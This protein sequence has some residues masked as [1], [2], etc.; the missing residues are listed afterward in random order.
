MKSLRISLV[1]YADLEC[2]LSK[3]QS[4]QNNPDKSYTERKAIHEHVVI[5]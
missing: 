3:Q 1:I 2:L 5:L 4:Y